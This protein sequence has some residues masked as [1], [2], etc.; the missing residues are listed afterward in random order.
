M[1][2]MFHSTNTFPY[3]QTTW[4]NVVSTIN[5]YAIVY[6]FHKNFIIALLEL[7]KCKQGCKRMFKVDND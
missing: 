4:Q 3:Y 7:N 6:H 5:N 1:K 2:E